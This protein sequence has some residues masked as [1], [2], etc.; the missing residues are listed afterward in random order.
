MLGLAFCGLAL[1]F[2]VLGLLVS[3]GPARVI[4]LRDEGACLPRSAF[5]ARVVEVPYHRIYRLEVQQL[6]RQKILHI[7]HVGGK[8]ALTSMALHDQTAFEQIVRILSQ[9]SCVTPQFVRVT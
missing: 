5:S 9:K 2:M 1:V 7:G 4:E 3:F 6:G 8:I